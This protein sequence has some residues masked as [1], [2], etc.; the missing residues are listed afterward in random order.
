[1]QWNV[2]QA[3]CGSIAEKY[4]WKNTEKSNMR[5][6]SWLYMN[7][8]MDNF[9]SLFCDKA[10]LSI[11]SWEHRRWSDGVFG[12]YCQFS[13]QEC[14]V[15]VSISQEN[16]GGVKDDKVVT[17]LKL[18]LRPNITLRLLWWQYVVKTQ[19]YTYFILRLF[20]YWYFN[21]RQRMFKQKPDFE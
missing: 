18:C 1:M 10:N 7:W 5:N 13:G 11:Y 17:K 9:L 15:K 6:C 20:V 4:C 16:V 2:C 21:R 14:Q 19:F 8:V 12:G 3:K